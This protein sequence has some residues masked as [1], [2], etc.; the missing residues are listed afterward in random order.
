MG[1][2]RVAIVGCGLIGGSIGCALRASGFQGTIVGADT[3]QVLDKAFRLGAVDVAAD[4]VERAVE[5]ADVIVLATPTASILK[6]LPKVANGVH[7]DALITDAG[8]TK[9]AIVKQAEEIFAER[10]PQRFLAGHPIAGKERSGIE[11]ADPELFR[12]AMWVFTP[13]ESHGTD[14]YTT[15]QLEWIELVRRI[16]AQPVFMTPERH[17]MLLAFTSHLPQLL[18]IALANTV[19]DE[20]RAHREDGGRVPFGGGLRDMTRLAQ[21]DARVWRDILA[22]NSEN[23]QQALEELQQRISALQAAISEEK[24]DRVEEAFRAASKI[25][26]LS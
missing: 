4:T 21:S 13:V 8:S 19:L 25:S 12:N 1:I 2:R 7:G 18:S 5:N 16:G 6:L 20:V 26:R 23:I 3:P 14:A 17:D 24:L 9:A 10:A 22:T 11:Q 15:V